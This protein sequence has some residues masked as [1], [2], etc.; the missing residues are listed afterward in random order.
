MLELKNGQNKLKDTNKG[1]DVYG[2]NLAKMMPP[3]I[4]HKNPKEK[5]TTNIQHAKRRKSEGCK[6]VFNFGIKKQQ[7]MQ[8]KE[9]IMTIDIVLQM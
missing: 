5:N 4:S 1:C 2:I 3:T 7:S 8:N 6:H 9:A